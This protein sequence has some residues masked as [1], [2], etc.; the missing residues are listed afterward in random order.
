VGK[1]RSLSDSKLSAARGAAAS[2]AAARAKLNRLKM[3]A[4]MILRIV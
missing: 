4:F 3:A 1:P 2:Q